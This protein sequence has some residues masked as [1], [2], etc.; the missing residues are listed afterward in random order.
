MGLKG[1]IIAAFIL[2]FGLSDMISPALAQDTPATA[3][4]NTQLY[5]SSQGGAAPIFLKGTKNTQTNVYNGQSTSYKP[6]APLPPTAS[7]EE[8]VRRTKSENA[9][10]LAYD[11]AE[12]K[13]RTAEKI[14]RDSAEDAIAAQENMAA[15]LAAAS[16]N[17]TNTTQTKSGP[18]ADPHAGKKVIFPYKKKDQADK[19][20]RLFN[21]P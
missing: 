13:R 10:K 19:P 4:G 14:A 11:S 5:N 6:S 20:V 7:Y 8:I 1:F 12:F 2:G 17:Q 9:R 18:V 15:N 3:S 21:V 16:T